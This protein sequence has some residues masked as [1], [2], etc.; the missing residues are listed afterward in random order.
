MHQTL[1][2]EVTRTLSLPY[3]RSLTCRARD[4]EAARKFG[5]TFRYGALPAE[6]RR[7]SRLESLRYVWGQCADARGNLSASST[8]FTGISSVLRSRLGVEITTCSVPP[9][10]VAAD[11]IAPGL[12][13]GFMGQNGKT[14]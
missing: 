12:N 11:I 5:R 9:K 6:C 3:R 1:P 10:T 14:W 4:F 7:Y 2:T 8:G 13:P